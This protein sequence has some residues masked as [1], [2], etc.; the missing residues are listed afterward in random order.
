MQSSDEAGNTTIEKAPVVK[1]LHDMQSVPPV[2][3]Q[4]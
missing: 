4:A 2:R 1:T 3:S